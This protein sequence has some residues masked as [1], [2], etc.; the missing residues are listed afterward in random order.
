MNCLRKPNGPMPMDVKSKKE[1]PRLA[2]NLTPHPV[3]AR[4]SF[5]QTVGVV[6]RRDGDLTV[7]SR[8][9]ACPCQRRGRRP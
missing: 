6:D 8:P 9:M 2:L 5:C 3:H 7:S 4:E 1:G